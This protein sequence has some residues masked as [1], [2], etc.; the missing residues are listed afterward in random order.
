MIEINDIQYVAETCAWCNGSGTE[1][2]EHW[3]RKCTV[4]GGCGWPHKKEE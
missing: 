3:S 2:Q 1:R 4:C